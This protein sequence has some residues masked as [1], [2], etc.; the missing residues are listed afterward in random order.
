MKP[1]AGSR[2]MRMFKE[3]YDDQVAEQADWAARQAEY[4]AEARKADA[5]RA[6]L[7]DH[8]RPAT[9]AEYADWLIGYMEAGGR[10]TKLVDRN[11]VDRGTMLHGSIGGD[12]SGLSATTAPVR[13]WT[14]TGRVKDIPSLYGANA[15][16]VIVPKRSRLRPERL[17]G[18]FHG[19]AGHSDF[20]FMNGFTKVAMSVPVYMDVFAIIAQQMGWVAD[21][22]Q[23]GVVDPPEIEAGPSGAIEAGPIE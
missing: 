18:T 12:G 13:W 20:Y 19:R 22:S 21:M 4:E 3:L 9:A 17:P 1:I 16:S 11:L 23:W 2:M 7:T 8:C 5:E 6:R 10:P 15:V 14:L